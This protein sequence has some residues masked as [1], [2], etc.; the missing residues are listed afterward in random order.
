MMLVQR[1]PRWTTLLP[2]QAFLAVVGSTAAVAAEVCSAAVCNR[3][4]WWAW[5]R[6]RTMVK[7]MMVGGSNGQASG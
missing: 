7:W 5:G 4:S 3:R 1:A 2:V 6:L